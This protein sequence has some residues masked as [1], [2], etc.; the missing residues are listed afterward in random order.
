VEEAGGRFT[1][2][3]GAARPDGGSAVSTNGRLHDEVLRR[4]GGV[5]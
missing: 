1:D 2:L 4:L 5:S 3:S